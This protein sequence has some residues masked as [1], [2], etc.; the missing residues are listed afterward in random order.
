MSQE[1]P[2]IRAML[3]A[4]LLQFPISNGVVIMMMIPGDLMTKDQDGE[5]I[6]STSLCWITE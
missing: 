1:Q 4:G 3:G 2:E 6:Q 5:M